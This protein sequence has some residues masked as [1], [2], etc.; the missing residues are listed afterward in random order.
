MRL[1]N[2]VDRVVETYAP[3]HKPVSKIVYEVCACVERWAVAAAQNEGVPQ[4][5]TQ[6]FTAKLVVELRDVLGQ[7]IPTS[8][9]QNW[10]EDDLSAYKSS[11]PARMKEDAHGTTVYFTGSTLSMT[12]P[13]P[14]VRCLLA[15]NPDRRE[16]IFLASRYLTLM[17]NGQQWAASDAIIKRCDRTWRPLPRR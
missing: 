14:T 4:P 2:V 16:L 1:Q 13:K 9:L 6:P 8:T 7:D 15:L 10:H 5:W 12:I 17:P 3:K 11:Y